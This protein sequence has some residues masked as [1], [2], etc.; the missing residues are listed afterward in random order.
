MPSSPLP[1]PN[2]AFFLSM[3][4][5]LLRLETLNGNVRP[6]HVSFVFNSYVVKDVCDESVLLIIINTSVF[7]TSSVFQ[8]GWGGAHH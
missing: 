3:A 8:V 6:H 4:S 1:I 2:E 7:R 5:V